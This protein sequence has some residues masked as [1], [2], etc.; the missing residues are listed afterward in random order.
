VTTT[1]IAVAFVAAL[2][3]S[4]IA[5]F[6]FRKVPHGETWALGCAVALGLT[7]LQTSALVDLL[8]PLQPKVAMDWL[9]GMTL[10]A[11]ACSTLRQDR[12]RWTL[13]ISLAFLFPIRL[14][15]GSIYMQLDSIGVSL[16]IAFGA[17]VT[18]LTV[19]MGLPD[20]PHRGR[21]SWSAGGWAL[22]FVFLSMSIVMSGSLTYGAAIGTCGFATLGVLLPA[23]R[24]PNFTPFPLVCLV[25]LAAA[26]SEVSPWVALLMFLAVISL[27]LSESIQALKTRVTLHSG[28]VAVTVLVSAVT[29][30]QFR[31]NFLGDGVDRSEEA[32][33]GYGAL[34]TNGP[35]QFMP[36]M[37]KPPANASKGS[38]DSSSKGVN[39]IDPFG[40][41]GLPGEIKP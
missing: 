25:G 16:G 2:L 17:W 26:F 11:A 37:T 38:D 30:V 20:N 15:W 29:F 27:L 7:L 1:S 21:L 41:L 4:L 3:C 12:Y 18:G 23:R 39:A 31:S 5:G 36:S 24:I 33:G 35:S 22:I 10:L 28:A 9:P 34:P 19:A 32:F 6:C 14:L 8:R 13:A 40:G